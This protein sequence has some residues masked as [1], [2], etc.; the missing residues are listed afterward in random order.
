MKKS[1]VVL[2]AIGLLMSVLPIKAIVSVPESSEQLRNAV[3]VQDGKVDPA[4]EGKLVV[5]SGVLEPSEPLR[6]ELTGVTLPGVIANRKV[7]TYQH[8]SDQDNERVWE[9]SAEENEYT[10]DGGLVTNSENLVSTILVAPTTLGEFRLEEKLLFPIQ[11]SS[12]FTDYDEASLKPGW[13]LYSGGQ[14]SKFCLSKETYL[15]WKTTG[16]YINWAEGEQ[17]LAY[18]ITSSDDPMEYTIVGIQ[19]G[20]TLVKAENIDS[21]S[22]FEGLMTAEEFAGEHKKSGIAASLF[23]ASFGVVLIVVGVVKCISGGR[24]DEEKSR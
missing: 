18:Y 15:P 6:D 8:V 24:K 16:G 21:I 19:K 2:I 12:E 20:D 5:V 23:A 10:K 7:W 3:T 22:T 13:N 4:N 11:K 1:G 9:W 14:E 17:K